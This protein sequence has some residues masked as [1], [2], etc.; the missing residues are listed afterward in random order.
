MY[1]VPQNTC[2]SNPL[3]N[4]VPCPG[5]NTCTTQL[6]PTQYVGYS[7]P[8]LPCTGINTCDTV[9]VAFEK[10]DNEICDLQ[11]Q[12]TV[13]QN[14]VNNLIG[15]TTTTTTISP[16]TTTTTTVICPGCQFYSISNSSVTPAE[17]FY[18]ACGGISTTATVG[19]FGTVYVCA[20]IGSV[21]LP[22]SPSLTLTNLGDCPATT[23]TTSSTSTFTSTSTT[24]STSSSSTSTTTSTTTEAIPTTTT[25]TTV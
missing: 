14:I 16:T 23:T 4:T 18:Y 15:T 11:S 5:G 13:L 1:Y 7:G 6:V 17:F 24:T 2:C 10:V 9:T 12:I 25:T 19:S 8:N 22:P 20:C 3:V 21:V